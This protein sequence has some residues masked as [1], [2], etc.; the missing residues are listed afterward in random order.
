MTALLVV[1]PITGRTFARFV[2]D[3]AED[4]VSVVGSFNDWSPG[5]HPLTSQDDGTLGVLAEVRHPG[6]VYFRYLAVGGRWFD[7]PTAHRIDENGSMLL[8]GSARAVDAAVSGPAKADTTSA[9]RTTKADKKKS[10]K[11]KAKADKK[12]AE[13]KVKAG[14]AKAGK[15]AGTKA[16]KGAGSKKG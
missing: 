6:D 2:L 11:R 9:K 8:R 3:E 14:K 16:R 12:S 5:V 10:A 4:E 15:G 13:Q 7:D 1:D